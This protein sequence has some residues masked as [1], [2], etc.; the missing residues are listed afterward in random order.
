[1]IRNDQLLA[2]LEDNK[3]VSDILGQ[4]AGKDKDQLAR[5]QKPLVFAERVVSYKFFEGRNSASRAS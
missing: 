5:S 1:M 2:P 4:I 3:N